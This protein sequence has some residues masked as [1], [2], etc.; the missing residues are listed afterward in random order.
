MKSEIEMRGALNGKL[1]HDVSKL[2]NAQ[3][4]N[5]EKIR[6]LEIE[7]IALEMDKEVLEKEKEELQRQVLAAG[8]KESGGVNVLK[9]K[10]AA[11]FWSSI[12]AKIMVRNTLC[13]PELKEWLLA[14]ATKC[15]DIGYTE[16]V[17]A[18]FAANHQEEKAAK[19]PFYNERDTDGPEYIDGQIAQL[20]N[21]EIDFEFLHFIETNPGL[22][23]QALASVFEQAYLEIEQKT[24]EPTEG[25][26]SEATENL[27]PMGASG[28]GEAGTSRQMTPDIPETDAEMEDTVTKGEETREEDL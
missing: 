5:A 26:P 11:E 8:T 16:R 17:T 14:F 22:S 18:V 6:K 15:T 28:V 10:E 21:G 3:T 24:N 12:G 13:S 1:R 9:W 19:F 2:Q 25:V 20:Q 27:Q 23:S 4:V 7:K